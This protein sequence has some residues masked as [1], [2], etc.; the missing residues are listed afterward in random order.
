MHKIKTIE[1]PYYDGKE[2]LLA[3]AAYQDDGQYKPAVLVAH[4]WAG[5]DQFV[6][7][8]AELLAQKGYV[9]FAIDVFGEAHCG[10]G[11]D[12]NAKL[13][14]PFKKN[15]AGLKKRLLA[16]FAAVKAL[17]F[18]DHKRI[19][20]VGYCFG[21]LCVLD[22]LRSGAEVAGVVSVHGLL[23]QPDLPKNK[24]HG[25]A[26]I[27]HGHDD[28]MVPPEQILACQAEL[29]E[30]KVDWQF[31]IYGHTSHAFTNPHANDPKLGTMYNKTADQRAKIAIDNFLAEIFG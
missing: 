27:L 25:K 19:A 28:P 17:P 12:E 24:T 13:I 30:A 15:R 4:T 9:G 21:G 23:G 5:R 14:A 20:A 11:P 31:H 8:K 29:T 2:R 26:L 3:Y 22:L 1:V 18:V 7:H 16:A 6:K 10:S